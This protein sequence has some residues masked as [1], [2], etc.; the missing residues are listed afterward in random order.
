MANMIA[1]TLELHRE[2]LLTAPEFRMCPS[3]CEFC[4]REGR[5]QNE[6]RTGFSQVFWFLSAIIIQTLLHADIFHQPTTDGLTCLAVHDI[7]R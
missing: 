4:G 7:T 5:S 3:P 2:I 1:C 6:S